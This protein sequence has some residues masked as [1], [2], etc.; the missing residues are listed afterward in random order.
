MKHLARLLMLSLLVFYSCSQQTDDVWGIIDPPKTDKT[1]PVEVAFT[2]ASLESFAEQG[3]TEIGIYAYLKDSLVF[4]KTLPLNNG[5]LQVNLP[6]GESLQTFAIANAGEMIDTDSLSKVK[7][8]MDAVLQKQVFISKIVDFT[9]D[10][11]VKTLN[12]ELKRLVGQ[13]VFQPKETTEV[14]NAITQFDQ[15]SITF[16]NVGMV[17]KVKT[18]TCIQEDYTV[19]V[20]RTAGFSASIY[21]LPTLSGDARTAVNVVYLKNN[22]EVNRTNSPLDTGIAFEPSKR[23][24]VNMAILDDGYLSDTWTRASA[25]TDTESWKPTFTLEESEF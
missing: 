19:K 23:S 7:V 5:N 16:T 20:N 8:R 9:S 15:L 2:R 24:V 1:H 4:G 17:Y 21:A 12:L 25:W 11:S 18:A 14:L 6:L 13:A 10:N 22:V 3:I